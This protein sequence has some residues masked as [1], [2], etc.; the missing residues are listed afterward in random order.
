MDREIQFGAL[1]IFAAVAESET[2]T[3][4]AGKL[5]VTQSA[6]SQAISQ[7]EELTKR[8]LV[9]RRAKPIQLTP[10]GQVMKA[11]ADEILDSARRMLTEIS[12]TSSDDLPNPIK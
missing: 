5:G 10:A 4:A 6:V 1:K 12:N 7:L 3:S 2:L 9:V 11:Y 8:D